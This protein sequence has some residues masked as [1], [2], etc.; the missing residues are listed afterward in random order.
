VVAN[1]FFDALPIN[2]AVKMVDGWHRRTVG[3]GPDETFRYEVEPEPMARF[4]ATLP[5]V[6]RRGRDGDIFEWRSDRE[7]IKLGRRIAREPSAALIIDY[8]H[9]ESATG[10]TLQ[11]AR[12][13]LFADP[14]ATP[15]DADMTAHVDFQALGRLFETLGCN[16]FGPI[17]QAVFLDR[18]GI[19]A[20]AQTLKANASR[21]TVHDIDAALARLTSAGRTGMGALFKVMAVTHPK[22]NAPPA[23][24]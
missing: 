13:H 21:S 20:R 3:L 12:D 5:E 11:A 18:L 22:L 1:E 4:E 9:V 17:E 24:E 23:F 7:T 19:Q 16:V 15:G 14:L 2:Q 10:E 8:G 6:V